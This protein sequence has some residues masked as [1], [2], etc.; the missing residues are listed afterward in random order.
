MNNFTVKAKI[1]SWVW[2]LSASMLLSGCSTPPDDAQESLQTQSTEQGDRWIENASRWKNWDVGDPN[3][4]L[5]AWS[6]EER[7]LVLKLSASKNL[8][9]FAERPHTLAVKVIQLSDVSGLKTLMQTPDGIRAVLS[10]PVEMIPNAVFSESLTLSP[11]QVQTLTFARQQDVKYVAI[12]SGFAELNA[13]K[14]IKILTIPVI[15]TPQF[16]P[17]PEQTFFD[18][19]TFG[20]FVDEPEKLPDIVRPAQLN[21]DVRFG[22]NSIVEFLATA[23]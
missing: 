8:N 23:Q 18:V 1:K 11:K 17:E 13:A 6:Y 20:I 4:Q 14:S 21:L 16:A 15:T 10:E 19:I 9:T 3:N 5:V 12:V 22:Q 2:I 7:A